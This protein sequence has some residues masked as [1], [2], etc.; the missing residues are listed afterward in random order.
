MDLNTA[1]AW[2]ALLISFLAA[3]YARW[4]ANA[5]KRANA[6]GRLSAMLELRSHYIEQMERQ[7]D[8][9]K[10]FAGPNSGLEAASKEY[11]R[12]DERLRDINRAVDEF[13]HDLVRVRV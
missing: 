4:S 8:Y 13:H 9:A 5:A 6:L 7:A 12:L 3:Y 2:L 11:A 1:L 10:N